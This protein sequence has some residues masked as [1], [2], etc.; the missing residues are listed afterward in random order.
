[1]SLSQLLLLLIVHFLFASSCLA[2]NFSTSQGL[3]QQSSSI[4]SR[5]ES[6]SKSC[7]PWRYHKYHNSSCECGDHLN[8]III[9]RNDQS[10]VSLLTCNCM[11]YSDHGDMV[12]VGSCLYLCSNNVYMEISEHTNLNQMCN[13]IVQ[14]NREGQMCGKCVDNHSPSPYSYRL[15]CTHCSNYKHNW[16]KYLLIAY[17]PLTVFFVVVISFR[18]NAISP[19]MNAF[20]LFCQIMSCPAVMSLLSSYVY[21]WSKNPIGSRIN[22]ILSEKVLSTFYG[23]WNLD[24]FRMIY[25]PFCLHPNIST[26]QIMF[27]D[28]FV[29]VYP[30]S[31]VF[32]TYWLVK[33]HDKFQA[34]QILW[35][36]VAWLCTRFHHHWN[37]SNSLIEAFGTFF[38]LSYVKII[39]TSF[40]ILMPVQLYNV[41]GQVVGLYSY[42][43]GSLKY[44]GRDHL[45]YAVLA[46]LMFVIF[47][48]M[49]LL[50]LCLYPCRCFQSCLN[51]CRLNSQ[52]LRTF[53]DAFQGCYKFEPYD[54]RYWAA[55]Y[56]FLRIAVLAIFAFTQNG[57]FTM[58]TGIIFI[59]VIALVV[60]IRPYRQNVFN[61]IDTVFLL[62]FVQVCFS[63]TAIF[64]CT[65]N[66]RYQSFAS[67][68]LGSALMFPVVYAMVLAVKKILPNKWIAC[69]KDKVLSHMF[70]RNS[71]QSQVR[72]DVE[73]P[74]LQHLAD[75][76]V[77]EQSPLLS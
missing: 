53:M 60:V 27:L 76:E 38:L 15:K 2:L 56:L 10:T 22:L 12:L 37:A 30:L 69:A 11:S 5:L 9:C 70:C 43:N 16:L 62:G 74:L 35:K 8:G 6:G 71:E 17:F 39:N 46:I 68:M 18:C 50:L 49:P 1:M 44:F 23:F 64:L 52:V 48:L 63:T 36:P 57:Y 32:L 34:V 65:F 54:C 3:V 73:D 58:V 72:E 19:S 26:L 59:P 66:R 51:C 61:A 29:A 25:S 42:Y 7:S 47:N 41:S 14:Q 40:E 31:L 77:N 45:P 24:F 4:Q 20:I 28:Y 67:F 33:L 75:S 55:F 13:S 21:F